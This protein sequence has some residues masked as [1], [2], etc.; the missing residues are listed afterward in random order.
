MK[1]ILI[2]V[3]IFLSGLVNAQETLEPAKTIGNQFDNLYKKS[4]SYQDYKVISKELFQNLKLQTQDSIDLYKKKMVEEKAL[5]QIEKQKFNSLKAKESKTQMALQNAIQNENTISLFGSPV[6][7][8]NYNLFLWSLVLM[9]L[10]SLLYFVFKYKNN[11]FLTNTAK[12]R[13]TEV[14][15]E[16]AD[17]RKKALEREQKL[18]RQLQ[19]EINKQRNS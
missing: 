11:I 8:T 1:S 5:L 14:E 18:R 3:A 16:L 12:I 13:L 17:Q 19:D 15:E 2:I 4:S 6:S 7:K 9:L 10:F